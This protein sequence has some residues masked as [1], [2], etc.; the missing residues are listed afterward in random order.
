MVCCFTLNMYRCG[1]PLGIDFDS[2]GK[3]VVADIH[4]GLYRVDVDKGTFEV[5]S[6]LN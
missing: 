3:L 1:R 5:K 4:K 2:S 6:Q